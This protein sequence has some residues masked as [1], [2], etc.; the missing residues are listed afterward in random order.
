MNIIDF[1]ILAVLF[2]SII[3]GFYRGSVATLFGLTACLISVV[4]AF[5]A[6]PHLSA[7]LSGNQGVTEM[8]TTYTD[9]GSLVGDYALATTKADGISEALIQTVLKSVSLPNC[10]ENILHSNLS[11]ASFASAGLT[12]VNDYVSATIVA[13]VLQSFSFVLCYFAAFI[14][15]HAVIG[16]IGHVFYY[17]VLKHLDGVVG[18]IYGLLR[19]IVTL[20]VLFLLMPVIRT[21]IPSD[22]ITRYLGE[23]ILSSVF[24]SDSFFAR[25]VTG[26]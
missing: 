25:I 11:N 26:I 19:G 6:G 12:T 9:A 4:I 20:Y 14:L 2:V 17:P 24:A 15:L 23:G 5:F 13:V 8:L 10:I 16:L 18:G 21:I 22:L 7:L 1:A 3:F